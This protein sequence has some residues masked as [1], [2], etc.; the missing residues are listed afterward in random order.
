MQPRR[1][2]FAG[3]TF[4]IGASTG[5]LLA[6]LLYDGIGPARMFAVGGV[7]VLAGLLLYVVAGRAPAS[8]AG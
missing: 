5:A 7:I 4:G 1:S 3:V 6:G 2:M 8:R